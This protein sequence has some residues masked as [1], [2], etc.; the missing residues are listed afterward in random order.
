MRIRTLTANILLPASIGIATIAA[1]FW[2]TGSTVIPIPTVVGLAFCAAGAAAVAEWLG[3]HIV[4][5]VRRR[6][7][8]SRHR[9]AQA[10]PNPKTRKAT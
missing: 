6:T 10:R 1:W 8:P 9:R 4:H 5:V 7:R 2:V 3:R